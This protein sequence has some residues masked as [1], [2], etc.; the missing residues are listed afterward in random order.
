MK[1]AKSKK[2]DSENWLIDFLNE[3]TELYNSPEF[4][5]SDPIQIPHRFTKL[6]D[7]EI[8]GFLSA[9]IAWGNRISIIRNADKLMQWMD[10]SPHDFMLHSKPKDMRI[11][12]KFVHRTFNGDD[13]IFFIQ[14]LQRIY[15]KYHSLEELFLPAKTLKT[16]SSLDTLILNF[17]T[18]FFTLHHLPRTQKHVSDPARGSAAKRICMF[19]RWMVRNDKKGVDF[20]LWKQISPSLLCLPLDIHTGNVSRKLNLLNRNANDWK[21]VLEVTKK[22]KT[23]DPIDPI[24][25]DFALF[26]LGAFEKF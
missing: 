13:C 1:K 23:F 26:G 22:L 3:K 5:N 18:E 24:K 11:F 17:R 6:Q 7:I 25:Y 19:L 16:E 15:K 14:S 10:N 9:T 12:L 2:N 20:G 4:I 21:A 8:A